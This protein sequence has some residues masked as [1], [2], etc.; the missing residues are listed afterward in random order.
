MITGFSWTK[1]EGRGTQLLKYALL[2]ILPLSHDT[3]N[4]MFLNLHNLL[5]K[6][7]RLIF[8]LSSENN[9]NNNKVKER[10]R[11]ETRGLLG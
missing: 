10:Q 7:E 1:A 11:K 8:L 5:H 9:N 3:D 6:T 4:H 2:H